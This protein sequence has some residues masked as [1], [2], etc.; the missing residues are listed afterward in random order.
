[1]PNQYPRRQ[2]TTE[3]TGGSLSPG[4]AP[5]LSG[6]HILSRDEE[7]EWHNFREW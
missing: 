4:F 7:M 3:V 6:Q 5:V 1:M 2:C